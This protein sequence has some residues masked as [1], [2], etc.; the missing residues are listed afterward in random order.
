MQQ[1]PQ[2]QEPKPQEI[3]W[4]KTFYQHKRTLVRKVL[5]RKSTAIVWQASQPHPEWQY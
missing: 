2:N 3:L 4:S 5:R 1:Q